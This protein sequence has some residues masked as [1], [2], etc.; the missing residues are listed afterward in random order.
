MSS[1]SVTPITRSQTIYREVI[2][3]AVV[4]LISNSQSFIG[5][6][7]GVNFSNIFVQLLRAHIPK[8]Q[9]L[10]CLLTLLG[11]LLV[12]GASK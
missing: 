11:Y 6:T 4:K 8:E 2:I 10:D 7:S 12:K 3:L 1:K 9:K 5:L